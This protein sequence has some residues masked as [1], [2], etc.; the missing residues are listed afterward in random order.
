MA[1]PAA[2]SLVLAQTLPLATSL[3]WRVPFPSLLSADS[4][5]PLAPLNGLR[6][7]AILAWPKASR[8]N[9]GQTDPLVAYA[10]ALFAASRLRPELGSVLKRDGAQVLHALAYLYA[11]IEPPSELSTA[12][13]ARAAHLAVDTWKAEAADV[14]WPHAP[15]AL[16]VLDLQAAAFAGFT[17]VEPQRAAAA[18]LAIAALYERE[19]PSRGDPALFAK[20]AEAHWRATGIALCAPS[21]PTMEER[22]THT[23]SFL[24][25]KYTLRQ[26]H[27]DAATSLLSTT[28]RNLSGA[29]AGEDLQRAFKSAFEA[30][31]K[32]ATRVD[33]ECQAFESNIGAYVNK[34]APTSTGAKTPAEE[35][36]LELAQPEE[37]VGLRPN[38]AFDLILHRA[39]DSWSATA[40]ARSLRSSPPPDP[41][42]R[43]RPPNT[44]LVNIMSRI[45]ACPE[46]RLIKG[47]SSGL[48][49]RT[50]QEWRA[51]LLG[52]AA[53]WLRAY[54]LGYGGV[55]REMGRQQVEEA[56]KL[57]KF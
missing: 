17:S 45:L 4:P 34:P 21:A 10:G 20:A 7:A 29:G 30:T 27:F 44:T 13:A 57:L 54:D 12:A 46:E 3:A 14:P 8:K 48:K 50:A 47:G 16:T 24:T 2:S 28:A 37:E 6:D 41:M 26:R 15:E 38:Y 40:Q 43:V 25:A 56:V 11:T 19:A 49:L 39:M 18:A 36:M 22:G 51:A 35:I 33:V 9:S 1:V 55:D 5:A 23:F 42:A 53:Q 31:E 32:I 52:A